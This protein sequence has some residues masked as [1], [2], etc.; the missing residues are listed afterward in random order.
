MQCE[1]IRVTKMQQSFGDFEH[2]RWSGK[3]LCEAYHE[4]C[5]NLT[6][7]SA[8]SLLD[9]ARARPG[10]AVLDVATGAG[11]AAEAA[12]ERGADDRD[13]LGVAQHASQK[14]VVVLVH[15]H[16]RGRSMGPEWIK[17]IH[18]GPTIN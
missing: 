3:Q 1:V 4:R 12:R 7:Q 8:P 18:S 2:A 17:F 15:G 6:Q 9:V 11:Y 16:E 5:R 13:H 10:S 14:V